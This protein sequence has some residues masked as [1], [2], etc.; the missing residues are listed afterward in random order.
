MSHLRN[1]DGWSSTDI[2]TLVRGVEEK[3]ERLKCR[4]C[5]CVGKLSIVEGQGFSAKARV[6]MW[7]C[8][9]LL[10]EVYLL[11]V[12]FFVCTFKACAVLSAAIL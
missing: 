8:V 7:F 6:L 5:S 10:R 3:E 4:N 11:Q 9:S 2:L 1:E 12:F